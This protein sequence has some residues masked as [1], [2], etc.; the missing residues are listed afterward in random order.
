[1]LHFHTNLVPPQT[2][3]ERYRYLRNQGIKN[4]LRTFQAQKRQK[5][6]NSQPRSKFPGSYKKKSVCWIGKPSICKIFRILLSGAMSDFVKIWK[7]YLNLLEYVYSRWNMN[8]I[9]TS[10]TQ[11]IL[12]HLSKF[13]KS[14]WC[15][16][17]I[18][19][20]CHKH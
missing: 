10:Y 9:E 1:M 11:N 3:T 17:C 18:K 19:M 8:F 2:L 6:Q 12:K 14:S 15:I 16:E 13:K 20:H 4:K 7:I 5:F